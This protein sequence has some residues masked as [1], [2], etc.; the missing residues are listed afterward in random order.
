MEQPG[1]PRQTEKPEFA[2]M[3]GP[4]G[5][6]LSE[7]PPHKTEQYAG[8]VDIQNMICRQG[9]IQVRQSYN[10]I[11]SMP[12]PQEPILGV[13]DFFEKN[14]N[15]IQVIIT[16]TRLIKWNGATS[17]WT[18]IGGGPLTGSATQ[19]FTASVV[20]QKFCFS[21]G[22]D[23]IQLWDGIGG[24]FAAA[25]AAAVPARFLCE[26][27]THLVV[28]FTVEGGNS[29]PQRIRWTGAGDPTDW[30]SASSGVSDLNN[31]LGPI[32]G[33]IKLYQSGWIFQQ[34]GI[35][36]M[37]PTGVG[38]NPF[39]F[40]SIV[41]G[42]EKGNICPY[43]LAIFN[44][45]LAPYVGKD[46][47]YVFNGNTSEPIGDFPI[48][49]SRTRLGARSRIFADIKASPLNQVFGFATTSIG[50]NIFNAYWLFIPNIGA[51]VFN[52]DEFN[53]TKFV[54]DSN[55]AT[56]G[57]FSTA[58]GIRI[59]D[60]IGTIT[61]QSWTPATL[62]STNPLDDFLLG[63]ASGEPGLSSFATRSEEPWSCITGPMPF[64]D[65]R[66]EDST[67]AI[68]IVIKDNAKNM[69]FRVTGINEKDQTQSKTV[70][71]GTGSGKMLVIVV[72]FPMITGMFLT[73]KIDGAAGQAV[74]ISEMTPIYVVA[75]EYK[76]NVF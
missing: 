15:R 53:W 32:T 7:I 54:F 72:V 25:A 12:D 74:D 60:L 40:P 69:T 6:I 56:A 31:D 30:V 41:T 63:F 58:G 52:F 11:T 33:I 34:W 29:F 64:N 24:A 42:R 5:G 37:Q 14:G 39:R 70:I 66:H 47:I 19:I 21:Q 45:Q 27:A 8:F 68:R 10:P 67:N 76:T 18:V 43:S 35:T 38:S 28:G 23:K 65:L 55:V 57:V 22:V 17:D 3:Q 20:N 2:G 61:A 46:N 1:Q 51:W 16:T 59:I 49:G 50:G 75:N 26:V 9:Q 13:F 48:Q 4:F 73:I 44:E 71:I 36:Q 62:V